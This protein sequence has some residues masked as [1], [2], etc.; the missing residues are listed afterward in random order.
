MALLAAVLVIEVYTRYLDVDEEH[1]KGHGVLHRH[2][3]VNWSEITR[4]SAQKPGNQAS[5]RNG[6]KIYVGKRRVFI[7]TT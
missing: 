6:L 1:I 5:L 7:V 4:I 2:I 3:S